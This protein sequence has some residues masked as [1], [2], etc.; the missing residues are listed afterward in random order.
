MLYGQGAGQMPTASAVVSDLIDV[1]LGRAKL[2]FDTIKT[3]SGD[4]E[5]MNVLDI[6]SIK[7]RY[8]LRHSVI[9]KP[10]VLAKIA[11]ILGSH[12]I[13]IAS[14]IQKETKENNLVSLVM[15]TH[16]AEEGNLQNALLEINDLDVVGEKTRFLRVEEAERQN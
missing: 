3:L 12:N 1:A 10:G 6:S 13:S 11:G 8:Y 16:L 2:T 14:V 4:S 15:M 9:D 5:K 7:T